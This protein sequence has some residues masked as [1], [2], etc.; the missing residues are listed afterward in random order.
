M[1]IGMVSRDAPPP[2]GVGVGSV[3]RV[4]A[5]S[6]LDRKPAG[7]RLTLQQC[8]PGTP[9]G[10]ASCH[11]PAGCSTVCWLHLSLPAHLSIAAPIWLVLSARVEQQ[12]WV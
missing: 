8:P 12:A 7:T 1:C 2:P 10:Q 4:R 3:T 5:H 6:M 9:L 11:L